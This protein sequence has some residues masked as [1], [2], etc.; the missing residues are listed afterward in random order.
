MADCVPLEH[1]QPR[2][3]HHLRRLP[4]LDDP[5]PQNR[6]A[7]ASALYNSPVGRRHGWHGLC[8]EL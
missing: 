6:P 2:L 4:T 5:R 3:L 8:Q 7:L 1:C